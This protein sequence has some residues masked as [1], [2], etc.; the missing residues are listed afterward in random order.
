MGETTVKAWDTHH[1]HP[2]AR[3]GSLVKELTEARVA[4]I[5]PFGNPQLIPLSTDSCLVNAG[6]S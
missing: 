3:R 2:E 1:N 6:L 5:T 4:E